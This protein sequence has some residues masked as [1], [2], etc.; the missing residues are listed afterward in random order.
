LQQGQSQPASQVHSPESQQGHPATHAQP[1]S[2]HPLLLVATA[3]TPEPVRKSALKSNAL[4]MA[5]ISNQ[6]HRFRN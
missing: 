4:I 5:I 1:L 6:I 2:Q 3:E